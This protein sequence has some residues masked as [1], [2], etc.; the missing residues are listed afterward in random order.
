MNGLHGMQAVV[1]QVMPQERGHV[2][3]GQGVTLN[4]IE[5]TGDSILW[6][7]VVERGWE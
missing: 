7:H 2:F 6:R 1:G 5:V 3:V 4:P